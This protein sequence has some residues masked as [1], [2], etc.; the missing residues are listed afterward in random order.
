MPERVKIDCR[1]GKKLFAKLFGEV[2]PPHQNL[3]EQGFAARHIT[4]RL[5]IPASHNMPLA[6]FDK[7]LNACKQCWIVFFHPLIKQ[8]LVMTEHI[9]KPV[10]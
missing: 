5:Q 10:Q 2:C 9:I 4:V 6:L 8:C 1:S 3:P 7:R